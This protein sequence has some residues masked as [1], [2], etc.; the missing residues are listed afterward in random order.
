MT[1]PPQPDQPQPYNGPIYVQAAAP[2]NGMG[3]AALVLGLI[4]LAIAL[5]PILG[6]IGILLGILA[7]VFGLVG[8][9][10]ARKG[11]ATNK[12]MSWFGAVLGVCAI[13]VGIV[14]LVIVN[15]AFNQFEDDLDD[16]GSL[17]AAR[18]P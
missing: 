9:G 15:D 2:R 16:I 1:E 3:V 11:I 17:S 13:A 6:F 5:I 4:G 18:L 12:V 14:G 8:V 7:L 10:R